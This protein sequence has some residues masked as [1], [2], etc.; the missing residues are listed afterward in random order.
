LIKIDDGDWTFLTNH[1]RVLL[2]IAVT[3]VRLRDIAASLR[4]S[5]IPPPV[6]TWASTQPAGIR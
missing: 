1:A 5:R 6:L 2:C 4:G 3:R